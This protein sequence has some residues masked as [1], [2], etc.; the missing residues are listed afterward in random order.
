MVLDRPVLLTES[1]MVYFLPVI[2]LLDGSTF[3]DV[4]PDESW[5]LYV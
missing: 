2:I 4:T 5:R 1:P 3:L